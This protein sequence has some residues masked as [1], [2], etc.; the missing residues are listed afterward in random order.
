FVDATVRVGPDGAVGGA[1]IPDPLDGPYRDCATAALRA[2]R[3]DRSR[4]DAASIAVLRVPTHHGAD[5]GIEAAVYGADVGR[6]VKIVHDQVGDWGPA[7]DGCFLASEGPDPSVRL[8]LSFGAGRDG[9]LTDVMV[10]GSTDTPAIDR[11]VVDWLSAVQLARPVTIPTKL[12]ASVRFFAPR[13][14][15]DEGDAVVSTPLAVVDDGP[16][17]PI[18]IRML[19][20][21]L[22]RA[23]VDG[24]N[25]SLADGVGAIERAHREMAA[26][27]A[28]MTNGQVTIVPTFRAYRDRFS[29]TSGDEPGFDDPV[30]IPLEVAATTDPGAFDS[31]FVWAPIP[32]GY[33]MPAFG[34]T[35]LHRTFRGATL[36][37][38]VL[39][40]GAR[41]IRLN[42]GMPPSELP[43]HE[44]WHQVEARAD[45]YLGLGRGWPPR[46]H[47]PVIADGE[48]LEPRHWQ[49]DTDPQTV[50]AWYA[51]V[52]GRVVPP[53][54]W[55]RAWAD[56]QRVPDDPTDL[57][58]Q[59]LAIA[60]GV[61]ARDGANDRVLAFGSFDR[62][63]F[64]DAAD[65]WLGLAW[66][67][68]VEVGRVVVHLGAHP[69]GLERARVE[70]HHPQDEDD[71][72]LRV[73][74]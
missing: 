10:T 35:F 62:P 73:G 7:L 71:V 47:A 8:E 69:E 61:G 31:V 36:S 30:Q 34:R 21:E 28:R 66:P 65:A 22:M 33:P 24:T 37:V 70:L 6:Q 25:A 63:T 20:V 17:P 23:N 29:F 38:C 12:R 16:V 59:G 27:V 52:L 46:N 53:S 72:W 67:V 26:E 51:Y 15:P 60:H 64:G 57:A 4:D 5:V 44:W 18:E 56:G 45:N 74:E 13:V 3:F 48:K 42:K 54:F 9:R 41:E 14:V 50:R 68:E 43:L 2:M 55:A 40:T 19:V 11:C 1:W 32:R 39:P 49:Y 58:P